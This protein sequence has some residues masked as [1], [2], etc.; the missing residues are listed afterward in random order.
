MEDLAKK[1]SKDSMRVNTVLAQSNV[2][3][4]QKYGKVE[5]STRMLQIVKARMLGKVQII[6]K[7]LPNRR[8]HTVRV[9]SKNV[10]NS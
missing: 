7:V 9:S 6:V 2:K 1:T 4:L 8:S 10:K 3:V 5:L